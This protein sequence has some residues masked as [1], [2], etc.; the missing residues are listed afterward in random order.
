MHHIN[1]KPLFISCKVTVQTSLDVGG[2]DWVFKNLA[3][4]YHDLVL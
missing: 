2:K 4:H 1:V 3:T